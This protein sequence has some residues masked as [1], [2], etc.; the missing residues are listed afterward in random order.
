MFTQI[1]KQSLSWLMQS[2]TA[3]RRMRQLT[4]KQPKHKSR[5]AFMRIEKSMRSGITEL[6]A[7]VPF[8]VEKNL[9]RKRCGSEND[10]YQM[11]DSILR[12]N[13]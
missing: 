4:R 2:E 5:N 9:L 7:V 3:S 6:S 12:K 1:R 10:K 13:A 11:G 8:F